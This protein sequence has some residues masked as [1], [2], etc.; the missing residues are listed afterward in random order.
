VP[1][2]ELLS[3]VVGIA[4]FLL[5]AGTAIYVR[6]TGHTIFTSRSVAWALLAGMY[7][8]AVAYAGLAI[9]L[10]YV[11]GNAMVVSKLSADRLVA[12]SAQGSTSELM[13]N[14]GV[15]TALV[16]AGTYL[17]MYARRKAV[18]PNSSL[19]RTNQSLRD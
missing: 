12:L 1:H 16:S 14:I 19:K 17:F 7:G 15:V 13:F 10:P 4:A 2:I 6:R 11:S 5:F 18:G 3:Q 8:L 9:Y